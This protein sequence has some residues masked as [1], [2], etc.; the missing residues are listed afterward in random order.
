[1]EVLFAAVLMFAQSV[2]KKE[3]LG[4]WQRSDESP[5]QKMRFEVKR[6]IN[7]GKDYRPFR[8][9]RCILPAW[10]RRTKGPLRRRTGRT[11]RG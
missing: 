5:D 6:W 1:M 10:R 4:A 8:S 9:G 7:V 2:E 3:C 11:W